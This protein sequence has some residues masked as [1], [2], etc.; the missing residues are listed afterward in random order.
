MEVI[1]Q[2]IATDAGMFAIWDSAAFQHILDYDSWDTEL[3][4][5]EIF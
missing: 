1:N 4:E 3:S 2:A 5:D